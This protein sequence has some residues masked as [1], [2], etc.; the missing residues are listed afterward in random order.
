[1]QT[2]PIHLSLYGRKILI[3]GGGA[4]ALRK[5]Q[6]LLCT[7]STITIIAPLITTKLR[8]LATT[9]NIIIK[10]REYKSIEDLD[11]FFLTI[12]AT[13]SRVVNQQIANDCK[14]REILVLVVDKPSEGDC[15][16]PANLRHGDLTI[17]VST[18]G[19]CPGY[20]AYIRDTIA[21][22]IDHKYGQIL[23][24]L[25]IEREKLLTN[26][27]LKPYNTKL[28]KSRINELLNTIT[29]SKEA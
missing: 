7:E 8:I 23:K 3:V 22:F 14:M 4:V 15:I 16:F 5:A 13:N 2:I 11:G 25:T 9:S 18:T 29:Q 26:G 17:S 21:T 24:Q 1:M 27:K 6:T 12:A 28:L 10:E 20:A 19:K